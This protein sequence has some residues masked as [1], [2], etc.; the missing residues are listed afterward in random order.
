MQD[1]FAQCSRDAL[2]QALYTRYPIVAR[3]LGLAAECERVIR[4]L[5]SYIKGQALRATIGYLVCKGWL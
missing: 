3:A 2:G 1:T 5:Q 4:Y